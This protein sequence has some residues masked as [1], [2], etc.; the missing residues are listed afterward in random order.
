[1]VLAQVLGR[2]ISSFQY[3]CFDSLA[4]LFPIACHNFSSNRTESEDDSY[5][6]AKS[7][8][9][10]L[11]IF[12]PVHVVIAI[13]DLISV[14]IYLRL[15]QHV[16]RLQ[17]E[18]DSSQLSGSASKGPPYGGIYVGSLDNGEEVAAPPASSNATKMASSHDKEIACAMTALKTYSLT[19]LYEVFVLTH[20]VFA[21]ELGFELHL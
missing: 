14:A 10:R 3:V 1:M 5:L 2:A 15:R 9:Q 11:V 13:P 4:E 17:A 12:V 7:L 20:L 18:Q 19:C 21:P 6:F 8:W 16:A